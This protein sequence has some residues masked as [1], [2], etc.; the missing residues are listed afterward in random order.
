MG[1]GPSPTRV[2]YAL[3]MPSTR[4]M[5]VGPTPEPGAYGTGD[6]VRRRYERIG[7]VIDVQEGPLGAFEE[8][9]LTVS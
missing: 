8:H 4:S 9:A 5:R 2:V 1:K 7:A 3:V 6:A